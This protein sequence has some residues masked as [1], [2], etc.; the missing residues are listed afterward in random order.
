MPSVQKL[1]KRGINPMLARHLMREAK[2]FRKR[3]NF[4]FWE[5]LSLEWVKFSLFMRLRRLSLDDYLFKAVLSD[6]VNS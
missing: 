3:L 1:V 5:K 6:K 4:R 2:F